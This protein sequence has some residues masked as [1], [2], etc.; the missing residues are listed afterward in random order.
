MASS[1]IRGHLKAFIVAS[2]K[3]TGSTDLVVV[4][5]SFDPKVLDSNPLVQLFFYSKYLCALFGSASP[6]GEGKQHEKN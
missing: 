1:G 6:N 4:T 5:P 3:S 2:L